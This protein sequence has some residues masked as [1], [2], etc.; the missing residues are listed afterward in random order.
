VIQAAARGEDLP[1]MHPRKLLAG[2]AVVVVGALSVA[3][4]AGGGGA[5]AQSPAANRWSHAPGAL[6]RQAPTTLHRS[7]GTVV[8]H[9]LFGEKFTFVDVGKKGDSPGDYGV[10]QDPIANPSTGRTV[11]VVDVQCV[12]AYASHC[13][14]SI[15]LFKRGQI[16]FDGST[17]T[18]VD[19]DQFAIT[20]GTREFKGVGGDLT[21]SFPSDEFA[22]LTLRLA[23]PKH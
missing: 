6:T 18:T 16:V 7:S 20:G 5:D 4:F 11:G 9:E 12:E 2:S 14:G 17:P 19:P 8:L 22:R 10:F 21:V 3:A 1:M 15:T 23:Y 13:R